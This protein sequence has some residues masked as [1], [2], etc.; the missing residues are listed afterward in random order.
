MPDVTQLI[1]R[2]KLLGVTEF[3]RE[4]TEVDKVIKK[5][6][7][8]AKDTG[9]KDMPALTKGTQDAEVA[10]RKFKVTGSM[11]AG[12][13]M[14]VGAGLTA[15]LTVPAIRAALNMDSL[16][17]SL[18]V[19]MGSSTAA[20]D[21]MTRLTAAS[22]ASPALGLE[23]AVR[24]SLTLQ[25]IGMKA[26][27]AR[28]LMLGLSNAAA[29]GGG[30]VENFNGA[31]L[32]L[33]QTIGSG[34]LQ[35]DEL[36]II[37][38]QIP[39][40]R[41]VLMQEFGTT[42][43]EEVMKRAGGNIWNVV[44]RLTAALERQPKAAMTASAQIDKLAA[45]WNLFLA[46]AGKSVMPAVTKVLD[47][48]TAIM[49]RLSDT[50]SMAVGLGVVLAGPFI[51]ATGAITTAI[52]QMNRYRATL[53]AIQGQSV[54]GGAGA[55]AAG[56]SAAF[57]VGA[58]LGRGIGA[59]GAWL[60]TA[61]MAILV[62]LRAIGAALNPVAA[63]ILAIAAFFYG[64]Y[65]WA[66]APLQ[67]K[68]ASDKVTGD[69]AEA[70][71]VGLNGPDRAKRKA[72]MDSLMPNRR[73][74]GPTAGGGRTGGFLGALVDMSIL[75]IAASQLNKIATNTGE[76]AQNT[77][78]QV[79]YRKYSL[80]GGELGRMGVTSTEFAS[81]NK[82]GRQV[83]VTLQ[84]GRTFEAMLADAIQQGIFQMKRQGAI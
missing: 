37:S 60:K 9:Q 36:R 40:F 69:T 68:A 57:R 79:D 16:Q 3:K 81:I 58:W 19:V 66:V 18:S 13:A 53:A 11:V 22:K 5:T 2:I 48:L 39:I 83:T 12:G 32:Q 27:E 45:S 8:D 55:A 31:L 14:A 59:M 82:G 77:K 35:G 56:G 29:L 51:T 78:A 1:T 30:G 49:D 67:E 17:R 33:T 54:L 63:I 4:I 70:L 15:G 75:S 20:A 28:R 65:R 74:I 6:G 41:K 76:T 44:S 25:S 84:N 38:E 62:P 23:G 50:K 71:A 26:N 80:G 34:K 7:Q 61:G 64:I 42:V 43:G 73:S 72:V 10:L 47:K 21:E 24:G 52:I 46:A